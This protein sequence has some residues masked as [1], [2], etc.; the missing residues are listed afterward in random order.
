MRHAQ[1]VEAVHRHPGGAVGLLDDS[2]RSAEACE[3][4]N[5]P[6]LSRPRK[7]PSKML[8]ALRVLAVHPPGEIEQ[9]LVED[10]LEESR[11][12]RR[13]RS[14]PV[15][16][17]DAHRRPGMDRRV[18]VAERPFIGR[19]LPVGCISRSAHK[20]RSCCLAKSGSIIDKRDAMEGEVPGGE[21]G[22]FPFVGHRDDV[23][24]DEMAP[25]AVAAVLAA[26]G[27]RRLAADRRRAIAARRNR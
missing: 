6:I 11:D 26:C 16:L 12:R 18:D 8:Q 19:Q 20:S 7:P 13:R 24:G 27:R 2:R 22:I 17:V 9:Q 4:S 15:L 3:R 5:T 1:H 10:P 21:P 23:G 14:A 25:V